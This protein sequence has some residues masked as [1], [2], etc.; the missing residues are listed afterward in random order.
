MQKVSLSYAGYAGNK[1]SQAIAGSK[2]QG[3][4]HANQNSALFKK[5]INSVKQ[6][7]STES[8][9]NNTNEVLSSPESSL[10]IVRN[11]AAAISA[12]IAKMS[13]AEISELKEQI[14]TDLLQNKAKINETASQKSML[15]RET[16]SDLKSLMEANNITSTGN[17]KSDIEAIKSAISKLDKED[18]KAL[19]EKFKFMGV[20]I[21]IANK[22]NQRNESFKDLDQLAMMNRQFFLNKKTV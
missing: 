15:N 22:T 14:S 5:D 6:E 18:A 19:H 8:S 1:P 11:E 4:A 21:N 9:I 2:S 3:L 13:D 16:S 7:I 12:A 17:L 20:N 10:N